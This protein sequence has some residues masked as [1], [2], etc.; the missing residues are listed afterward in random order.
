MLSL[1]TA[2]LQGLA[3]IP[4][5]LDFLNELNLA[6]R[7]NQIEKNQQAIRASFDLLEK[8]KTPKDIQD[9]ATALSKSWNKFS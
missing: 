6:A 2:A 7:L 4:K 8:A 5:I 1:I 9:A 3:A